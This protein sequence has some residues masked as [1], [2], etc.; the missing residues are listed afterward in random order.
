MGKWKCADI[1]HSAGE[2]GQSSL[3]G[4]MT[5]KK[6]GTITIKQD[7]FLLFSRRITVITQKRPSYLA[8]AMKKTEIPT[9]LRTSV[10]QES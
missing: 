5:Q 4:A 6:G 7:H 1:H 8:Q 9:A 3:K 10:S 2:K